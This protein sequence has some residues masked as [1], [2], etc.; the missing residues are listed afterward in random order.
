MHSSTTSAATS[1]FQ[2]HSESRK[3]PAL[4]SDNSVATK[5]KKTCITICNE[6]ACNEENDKKVDDS[7]K[8]C[9]CLEIPTSDTLAKLDSCDHLYCFKC[10]EQWS[11]REN[12]CPQ[13]KA[14]FT[15][16]E[17]VNKVLPKKGEPEEE[18][19]TVK[20]VKERDQSSD[21]MQPFH[22]IFGKCNSNVSLSVCRHDILFLLNFIIIS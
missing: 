8:C 21:F 16:I 2:H 15:Q 4:K 20:K 7:Q 19:V 12:S 13:C 14:R 11:E 17:L 10:I 5:K 18:N 3:R 6:T 22:Q 1:S 9:I